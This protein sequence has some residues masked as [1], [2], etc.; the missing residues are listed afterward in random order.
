M[1]YFSCHKCPRL[2]IYAVIFFCAVNFIFS[3]QKAETEF[4]TE[5]FL[6]EQIEWLASD[7]RNGRFAGTIHEADAANYIS[8]FFLVSGLLPAINNQWYIQQFELTGPI[9]QVME[10]DGYISRNVVGL[11]PGTAFPERYI[12]IGAHYD[13]Q[14]TGGLISMDSGN[15]Q[16]IHN[17]ADDNASGTA[18]LM[19]LANRFA[20]EPT[21]N[22][23]I[24]IAFSGE[25]LGLLGARHFVANME[26]AQDSVLAM[27][28]MDMIG[29]LSDGELTIFGT[30]T[31]TIWDDLLDGV[32][33]DS[34]TITRTPGGMGSSDHA[35]FYEAGIPVL[36]YFTGTHEDYHR[37]SDT[38]DKINY[39]GLEWVLAHVEET[40]RNLDHYSPE[41]IE[42]RESTDPRGVSMRR[43]GVSLGVIPDYTYSGE[44][45]RVESV[46]SGNS[47][48][49]AG[50]MDGDVI[51]TMAG[52]NIEDIYDYME[53]MEH[54]DEGDEFDIIILRNNEK[55]ELT[56][57]F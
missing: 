21:Q 27:I 31:A 51:I 19:W 41:E 11:V 26:M 55:L 33:A 3:C 7:E 36:H 14:G 15:E 12:I 32:Q 46:R 24:F 6:A 29:R 30:G 42:F 54:V 28:N 35:A 53:I 40:I 39:E 8:D 22:T 5:N 34:L 43:D 13:G 45:L 56:V 44:G 17:S 37:A 4:T 10:M 49:A 1:S 16:D 47:A 50:M 52:R 57:L 2:Y 20:M 38:A 18:G 48:E 9:A 25:E 23:L